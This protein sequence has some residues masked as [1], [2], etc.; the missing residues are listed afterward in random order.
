ML[1]G[2]NMDRNKNE[3]E[4]TSECKRAQ[5]TDSVLHE[6]EEVPVMTLGERIKEHRKGNGL[7]Q[8]KLAELAGV[9]RQAVTKW[10]NG[11][12]SPST[13]N[14]FRL[15]EIFGTTVDLLLKPEE[16]QNTDIEGISNTKQKNIE[17]EQ[18]TKQ[19]NIKG[20][21][22]AEQKKSA[23]LLARGKH[24]LLTALL[25]AAGFL[26][27]YLAEI[28]LAGDFSSYPIIGLL[29][30]TSPNRFPYLFG[31]L[32][33]QRLFWIALLISVF[34]A[35]WGKSCFSLSTFAGFCAG[36]LLGELF[37]GN[38][39]GAA[40]GH[41]HYGWAVW[42]FTFLFSIVMGIILEELGV[43]LPVLRS[44][45]FRIWCAVFLIGIIAILLFVRLSIQ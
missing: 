40:Y 18:N 13:E 26:L 6:K 15:A 38:P 32:V 28:I 10:E 11:Q 43:E 12:S 14:L 17:E 20:E 33:H 7:S 30:D 29:T 41:G 27:I 4:N 8:E 35:L 19:E 24:N 23:R 1:R 45:K 31:W 16:K 44:R 22:N 5:K 36:L 9:S 2:K 39:A 3:A 25:V 42:G 37:G 21:Q 34:P